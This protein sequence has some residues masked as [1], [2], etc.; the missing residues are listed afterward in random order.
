MIPLCVIFNPRFGPYAFLIQILLTQN[1]LLTKTLFWPKSF[2]TQFFFIGLDRKN[3]VGPNIFLT[4]L[5]CTEVKPHWFVG[6]CCFCIIVVFI[7]DH[8][9][10]L[11]LYH[12]R[13]KIYKD[14]HRYGW[15][16][17]K[18]V[19]NSSLRTFG[20]FIYNCLRQLSKMD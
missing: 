9:H 10:W 20:I 3:F 14:C 1:F 17:S 18:I 8:N 4:R 6:C 13:L 5:N 12:N 2:E 19:W 7:V 11:F 15:Y 16:L